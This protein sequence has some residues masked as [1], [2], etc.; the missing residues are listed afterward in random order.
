MLIHEGKTQTEKVFFKIGEVS[1]ITGLEP[2]VLRF[3][4]AEFST[5]HPRKNR[6]GQRVYIDRDIQVILRIKKMLYEE[7]FTIAGAKKKINEE[8][9]PKK[10]DQEKK[11][12]S[13]IINRIKLELEDILQTL[14][15]KDN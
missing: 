11:G 1:H 3:W 8:R 2:Y 14:G 5:L 12:N 6:G 15:P 7:G 10:E 9:Q 4:E 13:K